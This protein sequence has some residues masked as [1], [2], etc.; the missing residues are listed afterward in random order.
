MTTIPSTSSFEKSFELQTDALGRVQTPPEQ[1]EALLDAFDQSGMS[2]AAFAQLHGIRYQTF[3]GW[4]QR[5]ARRQS[6]QD[7]QFREVVVAT[8]KPCTHG[9]TVELPGG[10]RFQLDR[11]DQLPMATAL[12]QYLEARR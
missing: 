3:M 5:R 10:G 6:D 9:L 2:G 1:R 8:G 11:A 7:P 12:L 4:R